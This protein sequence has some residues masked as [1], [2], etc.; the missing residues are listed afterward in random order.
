MPYSHTVTVSLEKKPLLFGQILR[1][2]FRR[3]RRQKAG[4]MMRPA[5]NAHLVKA[6][7]YNRFVTLDP[8]PI[9]SFHP[10]E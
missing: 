6:Q 2:R 5:V 1:G 9:K 7:G 4:I 10:Y 8:V 3:L